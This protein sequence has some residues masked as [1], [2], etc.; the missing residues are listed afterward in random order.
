MARTILYF[1][2]FLSAFNFP[3]SSQARCRCI[4]VRRIFF[5]PVVKS[6]V[7]NVPAAAETKSDADKSDD[8]QR[9]IAPVMF[10]PVTAPSVTSDVE[11]PALE[12]DNKGLLYTLLEKFKQNVVRPVMDNKVTSAAVSVATIAVFALL[13]RSLKDGK[14]PSV[15]PP[16]SPAPNPAAGLEGRMVT[17][18]R[19]LAA[20]NEAMRQ[21]LAATQQQT[22]QV[23]AQRREIAALQ[24]RP[25]VAPAVAP[26][27]QPQQPQSHVT[28]VHIPPMPPQRTNPEFAQLQEGIQRLADQLAQLVEANNLDNQLRAD[29]VPAILALDEDLRGTHRVMT[30]LQQNGQPVLPDNHQELLAEM[31]QLRGALIES[32][33][34]A[35]IARERNINLEREA[36]GLALERADLL[37]Q[38]DLIK[39]DQGDQQ[40]GV[41]DDQ[42]PHDQAPV[43]A[44]AAAT[45]S[46]FQQE[47]QPTPLQ[48]EDV[49][50]RLAAE[51]AIAGGQSRVR[52]LEAYN[53]ELE[54]RNAQSGQGLRDLLGHVDQMQAQGADNLRALQDLEKERDGLANALRDVQAEFAQ[55]KTQMGSAATALD[56]MTN[57]ASSG[58]AALSDEQ[59]NHRQ[60]KDR[61]SNQLV[62][63][64]RDLTAAQ[65]QVLR[66]ETVKNASLLEQTERFKAAFG[67]LVSGNQQQLVTFGQEIDTRLKGLAAR[68]DA[69]DRALKAASAQRQ[70]LEARLMEA[71]LQVSMAQRNIQQME[72][73]AQQQDQA[74][75]QLRALQ[76]TAETNRRHA[77]QLQ[78]REQELSALLADAEKTRAEL[79]RQQSDLV[80]QRD[81]MLHH[82]PLQ[83]PLM[84][85]VPAAAAAPNGYHSSSTDEPDEYLLSYPDAPP[86]V[87]SARTLPTRFAAPAPAITTPTPP[88]AVMTVV[89]PPAAPA[90]PPASRIV[91]Q[92]APTIPAVTPSPS[93][94]VTPAAVAKSTPSPAAAAAAPSSSAA[95]SPAPKSSTTSSS[96]STASSSASDNTAELEKRL[97]GLRD[98][99]KKERMTAQDRRALQDEIRNT[100]S[101][102]KR[103]AIKAKGL[104]RKEQQLRV[105]IAKAGVVLKNKEKVEEV[106]EAGQAALEAMEEQQQAEKKR[107][108]EATKKQ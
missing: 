27:P 67:Q 72:L 65:D 83:R 8:I 73:G 99:L 95:K 32:Q 5:K 84:S 28:H 107:L 77:A 41:A 58:A 91:P 31:E 9:N 29:I 23:E 38:L 75:A 79:D 98:K 50:A 48:D 82:I 46:G 2:V 80:R 108:E 52:H 90:T 11:E 61:L 66:A 34:V 22:A 76:L 14:Q 96:S 101:A 103:L 33:R 100:E 1:L 19:E 104:D 102:I 94:L 88:P 49:R 47:P 3:L 68:I 15:T 71:D 86:F 64:R 55:A 92:P 54:H 53:A 45:S 81:L 44:A 24:Q 6:P 25:P 17:L 51:I 26:A 105:E 89:T 78:H 85:P 16:A 70:Q 36:D 35:A 10:A 62:A 56:S 42:V 18:E 39:R 40:N 69:I 7:K 20:A 106:V 93:S 97:A 12:K 30:E 74:L 63:M 13:W 4:G 60:E 43:G 21:Q 57:M 87:S 37:G 59:E